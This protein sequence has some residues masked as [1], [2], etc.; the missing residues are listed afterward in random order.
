MRS[1]TGA[2]LRRGAAGDRARAAEA[3][4]RARALDGLGRLMPPS[5][6]LRCQ[7]AGRP[8]FLPPLLGW[9]V[10]LIVAEF[11]LSTRRGWEDAQLRLREYV[12]SVGA[13]AVRWLR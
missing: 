7:R 1:G 11:S 12:W 6:A 4:P 3:P 5:G 9:L 8:V 10:G 2:S 13:R